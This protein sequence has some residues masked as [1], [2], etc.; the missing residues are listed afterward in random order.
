MKTLVLTVSLGIACLFF[1]SNVISQPVTFNYSKAGISMQIPDDWNVQEH[2][3]LLM[4]PQEGNLNLEVELT[5]LVDLKAAVKL[6][7]NELKEVFLEDTLVIIK[8]TKIN[9]MPGK[10]VEKKTDIKQVIFCYL[11]KPDGKIIE[12]KC[13]GDTEAMKNN[14]DKVKAIMNSVKPL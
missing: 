4:M 6:A 9:K 10:I 14:A 8:D 13:S 11:L 12:L 2:I 5:D 1:S 3:L 7:Q